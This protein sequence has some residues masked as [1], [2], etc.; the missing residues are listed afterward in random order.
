MLVNHAPSHSYV[1]R[2]APLAA[3]PA[4]SPSPSPLDGYQPG[5]YVEPPP[6]GYDPSSPEAMKLNAVLGA[7]VAGAVVGIAGGLAGGG[8]GAAAGALAVGAAGTGIWLS[9]GFAEDLGSKK[10]AAIGGGAGL[11]VGAMMGAA[12]S[13]NP[14]AA[15]LLGVA[16]GFGGAAIA[17]NLIG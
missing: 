1:S 9:T 2:Q 7:G 16:G 11:I 17:G 3:R 6:P 10:L 13:G 14:V 4:M 5:S 15:V 8:V 12:S